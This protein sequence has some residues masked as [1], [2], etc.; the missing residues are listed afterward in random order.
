MLRLVLCL[1]LTALASTRAWEQ[2]NP[3]VVRLNGGEAIEGWQPHAP[4]ESCFQACLAHKECTTW[5]SVAPGC[6][7]MANVALNL[8]RGPSQQITLETPITV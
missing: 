5:T 6:A 4:V 8:T 7:S 1:A 2:G 3:L